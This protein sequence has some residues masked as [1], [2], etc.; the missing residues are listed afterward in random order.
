MEQP[1]SSAD[2]NPAVDPVG[3]Q[4]HT[5]FAAGP[6][7]RIRSSLPLL[8]GKPFVLRR[9][10]LFVLLAWLP[11]LALASLISTRNLPG[12]VVRSDEDAEDGTGST[13]AATAV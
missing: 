1:L 4:A 8:R 5:L 2:T 9:V 13:A 12:Q 10:L 11:L 7:L 3:A 6:L